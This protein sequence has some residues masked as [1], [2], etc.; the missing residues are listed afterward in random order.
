[1][2]IR[3]EALCAECSLHLSILEAGFASWNFRFQPLPLPLL[4]LPILAFQPQVK[5]LLSEGH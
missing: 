3:F 5:N 1:M 4:S 2:C